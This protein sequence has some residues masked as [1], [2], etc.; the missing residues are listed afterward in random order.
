MLNRTNRTLSANH[1]RL[2]LG[3]RSLVLANG[4]NNGNPTLRAR[5]AHADS[6]RDGMFGDRDPLS[7]SRS[8]I[9]IPSTPGSTPVVPWPVAGPGATPTVGGPVTYLNAGPGQP[10]QQ[11]CLD[12]AARGQTSAR[13]RRSAERA[14]R[15]RDASEAKRSHQGKAPGGH[16]ATAVGT[17]TPAAAITASAGG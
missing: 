3:T 15:K 10:G 9:S 13:S 16:R 11:G 7:I 6:M 17:T 14:E 5:L 4:L 2:N 8:R 1:N 12:P